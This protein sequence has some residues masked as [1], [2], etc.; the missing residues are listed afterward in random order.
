MGRGET[1]DETQNARLI[2]ARLVEGNSPCVCVCA[3]DFRVLVYTFFPRCRIPN[4][5]SASGDRQRDLFKSQTKKSI[6]HMQFYSTYSVSF[7]KLKSIS[8]RP[9][10]YKPLSCH[11]ANGSLAGNNTSSHTGSESGPDK[12]PAPVHPQHQTTS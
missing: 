4:P 7:Y 9:L 6:Y 5:F 2:V 8:V 10:C 12:Y 11:I 3:H 1:Q